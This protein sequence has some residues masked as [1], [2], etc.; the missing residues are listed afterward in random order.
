MPLRARTVLAKFRPVRGGGTGADW[1][2]RGVVDI[3]V[4]LV[5]V[6]VSGLQYTG[7]AILNCRS[8]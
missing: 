8:R 7:A 6:L 1:M 5:L 3:M 2:E 4:V